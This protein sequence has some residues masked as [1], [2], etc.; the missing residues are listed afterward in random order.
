V[1][2]C[3]NVDSQRTLIHGT[4]DEIA[5]EVEHLVRALGRPEGG[6]IPLAD[7]GEDHHIVPPKNVQ[8]MEEAFE[9]YRRRGTS[10]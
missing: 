7:C 3:T 9:K 6:L 4:P 1:C 5:A 2:F 10:L 8:A